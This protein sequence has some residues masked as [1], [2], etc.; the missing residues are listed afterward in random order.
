MNKSN[1]NIFC[2]ASFTAICTVLFPDH[3]NAQ[4][5]LDKFQHVTL[6]ELA[7][8]PEEDWLMWRRTANHW[9]YSP[10]DQINKD[11]G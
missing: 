7:N 3:G 8:P 9:G 5:A 1:L 2:I 6:D 4:S 11:N 10:L